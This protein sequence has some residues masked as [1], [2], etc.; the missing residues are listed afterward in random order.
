MKHYFDLAELVENQGNVIREQ[1]ETIA[2]LL[3]ENAEQENMI[4]VL[5][6]EQ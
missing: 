6:S 4:N 3:N 2:R 5:M 1:S